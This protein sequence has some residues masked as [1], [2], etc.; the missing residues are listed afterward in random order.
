MVGPVVDDGVKDRADI[1]VEA[2]F[3]VEVFD[4]GADFGFANPVFHHFSLRPATKVALFSV[5]T[6]STC[7]AGHGP[8]YGP[9]SAGYDSFHI[10]LLSKVPWNTEKNRNSEVLLCD[11]MKHLPYWR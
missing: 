4:K 1:G 2:N 3:G 10:R 5:H 6:L 8:S 11:S 7:S 9:A